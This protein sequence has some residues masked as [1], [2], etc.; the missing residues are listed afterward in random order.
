M[1]RTE[2]RNG[3][4]MAGEVELR[5]VRIEKPE[6]VN[7][8]LGQSHF[9]KTVEDLYEAIAGISPN[10]RFGIAFC[11]SSGDRLVR[12]DGNDNEMKELAKGN[13]LAIGAGHSFI[14]FMRNCYPISVLNAIKNVQEICSIYC[15]TANPAEVVIAESGQGRGILGVIDGETPRGVEGSEDTRKRIE[16]LRRFG[17]KRG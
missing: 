14:V 2:S 5:L 17:Y 4:N 13:A 8:I 11:E 15:A 10:A 16:L 12:V 7:F 6:D 3:D 1:K 9:I